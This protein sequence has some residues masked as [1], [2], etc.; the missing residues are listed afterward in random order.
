[1]EAKNLYPKIPNYSELR[2]NDIVYDDEH[3]IV[4]IEQISGDKM[5]MY[6][7]VSFEGKKY[8]SN[9]YKIPLT[10]KWLMYFGFH[11]TEQ[12]WY[13]KE[14]GDNY[15]T[16]NIKTYKTSLGSRKSIKEAWNIYLN[17]CC[18]VNELQNLFFTLTGTE[19]E[20]KDECSTCG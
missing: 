15:L 6:T 14:F 2:I 12:G 10:E 1:M 8:P 17:E 11:Y 3:N 13:Y 19:L 5:A 16:I 18:F 9:I 7:I 20:L 4:N